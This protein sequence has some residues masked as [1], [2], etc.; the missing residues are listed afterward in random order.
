[1]KL[2]RPTPKKVEPRKPKR[3]TNCDLLKDKVAFLK[4]HNGSAEEIAELEAKIVVSKRCKRSKQKGGDYEG[5]IRN[6]FNDRFPMFTL[7]RTQGSGGAHKDI[8][9]ET[10]RGDIANFSDNDFPLSI[11]CK[12]CAS[13]SLPSWWK[14]AESD[15]VEGKTPIVV[16]KQQQKIK[17][18]KVTQKKRDFVMLD[19]DVFLYL[20]ECY[21]KAEG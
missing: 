19:L 4:S 9:H 8:Q 5:E 6:K 3:M 7:K 10:L 18:G 16:F 12:N 11:E 15:C 2:K 13:W 20:F 1:M 21:I 17:D 14:Q